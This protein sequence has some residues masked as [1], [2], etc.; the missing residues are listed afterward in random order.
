MPEADAE[1]ALSKLSI[2]TKIE[3]WYNARDNVLNFEFE[4]LLRAEFGIS[5][6]DTAEENGNLNPQNICF[7]FPSPFE[8]AH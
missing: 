5:P 8:L 7:H 3:K 4:F 6:K 1:G 2:T